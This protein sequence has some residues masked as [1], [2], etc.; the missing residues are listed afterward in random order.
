MSLREAIRLRFVAAT[1]GRPVEWSDDRTSRGDFDG[2][3]W[4]LEVFDV[5]AVE[6]RSLHRSLWPLREEVRKK[7][8]LHLAL[9]FHTP[10]AT[11]KR[12]A[13]MHQITLATAE[14]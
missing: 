8:R 14:S 7:H 9:I 6:E 1:G 12:Y 13:W 3:E 10:E 2:R 4:T 11:E 5:P